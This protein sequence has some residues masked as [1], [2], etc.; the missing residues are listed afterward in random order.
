VAPFPIEAAPTGPSAVG[1]ETPD[2]VEPL[3]AGDAAP[4]DG[5]SPDGEGPSAGR[6]IAAPAGLA[7]EPPNDGAAAPGTA[8]AQGPTGELASD[9]EKK[10]PAPLPAIE[11][12]ER[13]RREREASKP[14]PI[15]TRRAPAKTTSGDPVVMLEWAQTRERFDRLTRQRS[16]ATTEMALVCRRYRALERS[17]GR[18]NTAERQREL[19]PRIEAMQQLLADWGG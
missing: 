9:T 6:E 14:P 1:A 12:V 2:G 15:R 4:S 11:A 17:I 3:A 10:Q 8:T 16:C 13:A 5:A 19:L 18:A 7:T